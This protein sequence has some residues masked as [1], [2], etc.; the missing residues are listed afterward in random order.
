[1]CYF[2]LPN[3][4]LELHPAFE[5]LFCYIWKGSCEKFSDELNLE[6]VNAYI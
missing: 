3:S 4:I 5:W 2:I 6:K 1:M